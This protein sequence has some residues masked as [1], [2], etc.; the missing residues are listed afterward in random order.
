MQR[1]RVTP[2]APTAASVGAAALLDPLGFG[3]PFTVHPSQCGTDVA[4]GGVRRVNYW[5]V[6]NGGSISKMRF[7]DGVASGNMNI[8]V[9]RSSG[10]GSAAVPGTLL[11]STGSIAVPTAGTN[12][13]ALGATVTV[14]PG[15]WFAIVADNTTA[16]FRA[17]ASLSNGA[18]LTNG[19]SA[20]ED[21]GSMVLPATATP[22]AAGGAVGIVCL[23]GV[24]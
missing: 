15:D 21:I 13:V 17:T 10:T 6:Y 8:G 7:R 24:A 4:L 16:T 11:T 22:N 23:I 19:F 12:E 14:N 3:A 18:T 20:F 2:A 9:Y 1:I 5:R